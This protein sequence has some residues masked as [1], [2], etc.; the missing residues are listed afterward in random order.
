MNPLIL[1]SGINAFGLIRSFSN[2]GIKPY[3]IDYEKDVAAFSFRCR[4]Y[5]SP[6]PSANIELATFIHK[7]YEKHGSFFII[8]TTDHYLAFLIDSYAGLSLK[9]KISFENPELISS[10]LNKDKL[11]ALAE[12]CSIAIPKTTIIQKL[13]NFNPDDEGILYPLILKPVVN[14]Q[15][16]KIT[17]DKVLMI[18]S[19]EE[20]KNKTSIILNSEI[21]EDTFIAQEFIEGDAS[22]LYTC[23]SY[24]DSHGK[25]VEYS[26]GHKIRQSPAKNGTIISGRVVNNI[27]PAEITEHFYKQIGFSGYA[28]IEFKFCSKTGK[29]YLMEINPRPGIWNY[30]SAF[31][32]ANVALAGFYH[33][34]GINYQRSTPAREIVWAL[35]LLDFIEGVFKGNHCKKFSIIQWFKSLKGVKVSGIFS[36]KDPH[37]FLIFILKKL[38]S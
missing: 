31:S 27:I 1:G 25:L 16:K 28:N 38:F 26:V 29:F 15:F 13:Q 37:L 35:F 5:K 21:A 24:S 22:C 6:E 36:Y 4:F 12:K 2:A 34:S 20:L 3:C 10:L 33:A 9:H 32:G 18:N 11:Y 23:T 17:G 8:P 30:S 14:Y 7:L 19:D